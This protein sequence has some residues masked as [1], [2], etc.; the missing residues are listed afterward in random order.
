MQYF[1][2]KPGTGAA[3][4]PEWRWLAVRKDQQEKLEARLALDPADAWAR[5]ARGQL[6][7][8]WDEVPNDQVPAEVVAAVS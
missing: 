5:V 8:L 2:A 4:V 1:T 3:T 6:D 7:L